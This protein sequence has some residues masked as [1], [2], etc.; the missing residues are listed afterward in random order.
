MLC[1]HLKAID[2]LKINSRITPSLQ[3]ASTEKPVVQLK[4]ITLAGTDDSS[5]DRV[6]ASYHSLTFKH[7]HPRHE[8]KQNSVKMMRKRITQTMLEKK[9]YVCGKDKKLQD[10]KSCTLTTLCM[11]VFKCFYCSTLLVMNIR[12]DT[13][14]PITSRARSPLLDL[15]PTRSSMLPS[16]I[17]L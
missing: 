7:W 8:E 15:L 13:K 4:L 2:I 3:R 1:S 11:S 6:S 9:F 17:I 14:N 10:L 5:S 16:I 12:N